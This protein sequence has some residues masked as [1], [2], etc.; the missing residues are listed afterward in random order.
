MLH[1]A[2]VSRY[3][4]KLPLAADVNHA[5]GRLHESGFSNVVAR[6]F[7]LNYSFNVLSHFGVGRGSLH[8]G[9]E[10]VIKKREQT[11]AKLSV[12]GD[13]DTGTMSTERVGHRSNDAN[14]ADAIFKRITASRLAGHVGNERP[15]WLPC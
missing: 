12:R 15:Q 13:P 3:S 6:F 4:Y 5:A 14:L 1:C 7:L 2:I 10:I 9:V 8:Q 11:S